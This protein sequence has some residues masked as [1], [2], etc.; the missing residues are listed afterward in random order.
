MQVTGEGVEKIISRITPNIQSRFEGHTGHVGYDL[1]HVGAGSM[2]LVLGGF[3]AANI[4]RLQNT[5]EV[6]VNSERRFQLF[7]YVAEFDGSVRRK[8][9][10]LAAVH[11]AL[12]L[13][14][15]DQ[16]FALEAVQAETTEEVCMAVLR[17]LV[18]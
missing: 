9:G 7:R 2:L 11:V 5:L 18:G 12:S 14:C 4:Y 8:H 16:L 6:G 10:L 13:V 17:D 15:D 3:R 1:V